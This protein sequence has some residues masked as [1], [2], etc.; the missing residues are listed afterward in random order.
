MKNSQDKS[1]KYFTELINNW[2]DIKELIGKVESTTNAQKAV[3]TLINNQILSGDSNI[4]DALNAIM[5]NT[6][7]SEKNPVNSEVTNLYGIQ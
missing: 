6:V 2:Q 3:N 5:A 1:N 4:G 7:W